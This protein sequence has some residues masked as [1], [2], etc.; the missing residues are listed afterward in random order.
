MGAEPI[1]SSPEQ[2]RAF[3]QKEVPQWKKVLKPIE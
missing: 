3:I 1:D 2:F